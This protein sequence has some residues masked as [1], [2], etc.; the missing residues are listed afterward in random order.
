MLSLSIVMLLANIGHAQWMLINQGGGTPDSSAALE[1]NDTTRGF[2]PTRMTTTQMNAIASPTEGLM[3]FNTDD[4]SFYY[5]DG[6]NWVTFGS[7]SSSGSSGSGSDSI[8]VHSI[9]HTGTSF[10]VTSNNLKATNFTFDGDSLLQLDNSGTYSVFRAE[11]RVMVTINHSNLKTATSGTQNI[12]VNG[13][14]RFTTSTSAT[15]GRVLSAWTGIMEVGDSI[16][17]NSSNTNTGGGWELS[18]S[19][20]SLNIT[21]GNA[22]AVSSVD[23]S[24]ILLIR[25]VK[26][27]NTDGGTFTNG[28]WR[29]R[30]LNDLQGDST[31]VTLASNEFSLSEGVYSVRWSAPAYKVGTHQTRLY[32]VSTSAVVSAGSP[33]NS[34]TAD[35]TG[36]MSVGNA[37]L[38]ID[39][40]TT[41]RLEHRGTSSQTTNGFGTGGN[42]GDE[43]YSQVM[44]IKLDKVFGNGTS[45]F[46]ADTLDVNV[47]SARISNNGTSATVLSES[48]NFIQSVNRAS[49]GQVDIIFTPG[50]F[51]DTPAVFVQAIEGAV[52]HAQ[53]QQ[54][55]L[56]TDSVRVRTQH[57]STTVSTDVHF[58]VLVHRQG[59]DYRH[60]TSGA[61]GSAIASLDLEQVLTNGDGAAGL[62]IHG[63]GNLSVGTDSVDGVVTIFSNGTIPLFIDYDRTGTFQSA[64]RALN[65]SISAGETIAHV[66]GYTNSEYNSAW[67]GY[68]HYGDDSSGNA[69][70]FGIWDHYDILTI[71]GEENVG[72]GTVSPGE[73]LVV[74]GGD[75]LDAAILIETDTDNNNEDH[76]PRLRLVQDGGG[77]E[78][79]IGLEGSSEHTLDGTTGNDLLI[80]TTGSDRIQLFTNDTIRLTIRGSEAQ[81]GLG[82][83]EPEYDFHMVDSTGNSSMRL[84][85]EGVGG[86]AYIRL[87]TLNTEFTL[88]T[89]ENTQLFRIEHETNDNNL[90][91]L[92]SN[93]HVAVNRD[94]TTGNTFFVG[95]QGLD[96]GHVALNAL[97]G[98]IEIN[99]ANDAFSFIDFKGNN[100][101]NSD[102]EGRIGYDDAIGMTFHT[103]ALER[104]TIDTTG[105]VDIDSLQINGAFKFPSTDGSGGQV[106]TTDGS[107]TVTW[108]SQP[109]VGDTTQLADTDN[110]TKIQVEESSDEDRIRFDIEGGER[111]TIDTS[112]VTIFST[113]TS[114]TA[115]KALEYDL[116]TSSGAKTGISGFIESNGGNGTLYGTNVN[117]D[118][119]G[120]G[121]TYGTYN[122]DIGSTGT[123]AKFGNYVNYT[124]G[125]GIKYGTYNTLSSASGSSNIFGVYTSVDHDGTGRPYGF[126]TINTG[127]ATTNSQ[128]SYYGY[129]ANTGTS[130]KYGFWNQIAQASGGNSMF[131]IQNTLDHDGTGA[132]YGFYNN[133]QGSGTGQMRG[134]YTFSTAGTGIKY[135]IYNQFAIGSGA[136]P[137]Y[138][139]YNTFD[140][141]GSGITTGAHTIFTG[142][143]N[144]QVRGYYTDIT[145]GSGIKYGTYATIQQGAGVG[146]SIY[147]GYSY[148]DH[149]GTADSYGYRNEMGGTGSGDQY[150]FYA[151]D[152]STG[153]GD[154]YGHYTT[155]RTLDNAVDLYGNYNTLDH[156]AAGISYGTFNQ[157]AGTGTGTYYALYNTATTGTGRKYGT[158]TLLTTASGATQIYGANYRLT[159]NGTGS[160]YGVD[161]QVLGSSTGIAYG[162]K[163][164]HSSGGVGT[165][166]GLH[167]TIANASSGSPIHGMYNVLQ[168]SGTGLI[169]GA[170]N[171]FTRNSS[172]DLYG[173]RNSV[174]VGTGTG[175]MFGTS[176]E[177]SVGTGEK[178]GLSNTLS[179]ASGAGEIYGMFNQMDQDGTGR[180][181]GVYTSNI[182]TGSGI[183]YGV[184]NEATSGTGTKYS[185]YTNMTN[186]SGS[187]TLYG[188]NMLLSQNGTGQTYGHRSIISG[189]G[190]GSQ[191][192]IYAAI[193]NTGTGT[194]YGVFNTL[195]Q[196]AG[197]NTIYGTY[198]TLTHNGTGAAYGSR[199]ILSGSSTNK[200]GVLVS[201]E[202]YSAFSGD[203]MIGATTAPSSELE[204]VGDVEIPAANDY[205]YSTAKVGWFHTPAFGF[206]LLNTT[207]AYQDIGVGS[208]AS[209]NSIWVVGGTGTDDAYF[210]APA[211]LPDGAVIDS[212]YFTVYDNDGTYQL[213]GSLIRKTWGATTITTLATT[214]GTGTTAT[215]TTTTIN[216]N[217]NSTVDNQ[218][219]AYYFR[220]QTKEAN[221]NLRIMQARIRYTVLKAD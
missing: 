52:Y 38:E 216:A 179:T 26:T 20:I 37:V 152:F 13:S 186:A 208:F 55:S 174:S 35:N 42:F 133:I 68:R 85:A 74:S 3:L 128:Y 194:K 199:L 121:S 144:G 12:V 163:H 5:Y 86:D 200:I 70:V 84:Q 146:N 198:S 108:S 145:T 183:F 190:S 4:S 132:V 110:D 67:W 135:G 175:D 131:G 104:V 18:I 66:I 36:N 219:Y 17:F 25:D 187:G 33:E 80:G 157:Y 140:H 116:T 142:S 167:N 127:S 19:A 207:G 134:V 60:N 103:N 165:K 83:T 130:S 24:G 119:D 162:F 34:S 137:M 149:D 57:S 79:Y 139:M 28:A 43:V 90:I 14:N 176:N 107:G 95:E 211:H 164:T 31:F 65:D 8:G 215:P 193:S 98:G 94:S 195:T 115:V 136:N 59:T 154:K 178:R 111:M 172:G 184:R 63:V 126:Y 53:L 9:Q 82:T 203:V 168:H 117:I 47:F 180:T 192:G 212:V 75:T 32:N 153:S 58:H 151:Y 78:A 120:S 71:T 49:A 158:Y 93:G 2:L 112:Q 91:V 89:E 161:N 138:G 77:T 143:G 189:T 7:G 129:L 27:S 41:F 169:Y 173:T 73:K 40:T 206:Q 15:T 122:S 160:V 61:S 196:S 123:G 124:A 218:T 69:M 214:A 210:Y 220:V 166:Y 21:S 171:I 113:I 170:Y 54:G 45:G 62:D 221:S 23:E 209:G 125:T 100:N 150:G 217:L 39:S 106:M 102:F 22:A 213:V 50:L 105:L 29:V 46:D 159:H 201:G 177:F 101:A 11:Q 44:I 202:D 81:M 204:V 114:S 30:D 205:T 64:T 191:V 156:D 155:V 141:D 188:T 185:L 88:E 109:T 51:T 96:S 10:T 118:N 182:G 76:N 147:G 72:I 6:T 197:T 48:D 97:D 16:Y 148:L 92:D 56:T 181:Y 87:K 99:S 1:L